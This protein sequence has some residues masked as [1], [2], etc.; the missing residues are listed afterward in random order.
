MQVEYHI[1]I[2]A[3]KKFAKYSKISPGRKF[4]LKYSIRGTNIL[5]YFVRSH[6]LKRGL[7][8]K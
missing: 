4:I 8:N 7:L 1:E 2:Y 5:K 6:A 3:T